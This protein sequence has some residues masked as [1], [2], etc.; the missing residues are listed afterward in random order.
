MSR[1]RNVKTK[2]TMIKCGG[3]DGSEKDDKY[4]DCAG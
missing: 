3:L 4:G 2:N 1:L